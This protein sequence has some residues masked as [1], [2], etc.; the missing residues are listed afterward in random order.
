MIYQKRVPVAEPATP[1]PLHHEPA[2]QEPSRQISREL[3]HDLN[4][5][6][7][8]I[9]GYADRMILKHGDNPALHTDLRIISEN[10]RRAVLAIRQATPR[11]PM[12]AAVT[13]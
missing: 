7:T 5:I 6:L 1:A 13:G 3:A 12:A 9:Q 4:N 8:I 11:S 10:A 2:F